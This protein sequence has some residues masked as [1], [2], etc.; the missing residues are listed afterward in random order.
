MKV[1]KGIHL[2]RSPHFSNLVIAE[3][4]Q[5]SI[6]KLKNTLTLT[7]KSLVFRAQMIKKS[8]S[9]VRNNPDRLL[10][11]RT[12][13]RDT[14][15]NIKT[16]YWHEHEEGLLIPAGFW[17]LAETTDG[18]E[19]DNTQPYHISFLR[20]YQKE[21]V[22]ECLKYK[23]A[24][25]VMATGT[26]KSLTM[27]SLALS[28]IKQGRRIIIIVP[29][30]DLVDQFVESVKG[31]HDS[32]T[33]ASGTKKPKLGTDILVCTAF[34]AQK[35][36]DKFDVV[37]T[38][39]AH[40]APSA[41]W[42]NLLGSAD[43]IEYVYNFTATPFRADGLD[44]AI[45]AFGGP[46]VFERDL[47]FGIDNGYLKPF[48]VFTVDLYAQYNETT[49]IMLS[50]SVMHTSAYK[51][52]VS[53]KYFLN[54]TAD[55]LKKAHKSGRKVIVLFKTLA[56]A[57]E[58]ARLCKGEIEFTV[59]NADWKKPLDD[60]KNGKSSVLVATSK[61]I[62]EGI[63]IPDADMLILCMQN[64]SD[65]MT[66]QALGRVLRLSEG[67]KK[68]IVIDIT[69]NGYNSFERSS[70]KR[71]AIWNKTADSVKVLKI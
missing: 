29:S 15:E 6:N 13:L 48:D 40:R 56:P 46:I 60:F 25:C 38:D 43:H 11:L 10:K 18:Y 37:L 28:H 12:E 55:L 3:G 34:S 59:A 24:T 20:G 47:K 70:L 41:T 2:R 9:R 64:S 44:L 27:T 16:E 17:G 53:N 71:K 39:E 4:D 7:N 36:I 14:E 54:K 65:G 67:K 32:V 23:R 33:G 68:P 66:Y 42:A 30:V 19:K 45:H 51:K 63:D 69:A 61:L 35:H 52:I 5:S 50:D 1:I 22:T 57:R 26:G 58:L 49:P 31:V 21:A 8:I 62:G